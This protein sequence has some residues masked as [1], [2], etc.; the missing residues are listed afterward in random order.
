VK[1]I[2][3][4]AAE[5]MSISEIDDMAERALAAV[6]PKNDKGSRRDRARSR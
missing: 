5:R 4:D 3:F 6:R 2:A 1:A